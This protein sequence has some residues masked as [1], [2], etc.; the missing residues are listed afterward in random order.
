MPSHVPCLT[1]P[2]VLA[3][4]GDTVLGED[5]LEVMPAS[6]QELGRQ[7]AALSWGSQSSTLST[8]EGTLTGRLGVEPYNDSCL[9]EVGAGEE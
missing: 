3:H 8:E 2:G 1:A 4:P 7:R 9:L 5:S 6:A